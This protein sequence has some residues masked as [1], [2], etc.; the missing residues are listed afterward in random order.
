MGGSSAFERWVEKMP[1]SEVEADLGRLQAEQFELQAQIDV[2]RKALQLKK[3]SAFRQ[4]HE[5][6]RVDSAQGPPADGAGRR[7]RD[8]V[9]AIIRAN[10]EKDEWNISEMLEALR[11]RGWPAN[12]HSVGV[13][14]SRMY[15]DGE[16]GR[17]EYGRYT[18]SGGTLAGGIG[19]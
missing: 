8:A 15:R 14:L 2:L 7:G 5:P 18:V 1:A 19:T 9:R 17:P 10:P 3:V 6:R 16:L 13:N 11:E 4:G 12:V